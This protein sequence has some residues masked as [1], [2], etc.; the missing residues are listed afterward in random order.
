M[1][2]R[3]PILLLPAVL[4]FTACGELEEEEEPPQGVGEG[5]TQERLEQA[6][7]HPE[8]WVTYGG[9]YWEDR[10]S[11]L[12]E[13]DR[14]T[15]A[16]LGLE[17]AHDL[18]LRGGHETTPLVVD[19]VMIVTGPWSVVYAVDVRTGER[20]WTYDP[21]VPRL[22]GIY[23]CCDRV[24]RGAALYEGKVIVGTLDGRL[25]AVDATD[26]TQ[27]W[28]V[29]TVDPDRRY[30]ITGA[31]RVVQGLAI[32][33]NG[34]AELGVRG[35]VTAYDAE[36]GD[37]VWRTYTVPGDPSEPFESEAIARAAETWTGEWWTVGGGGTAWDAMA[38]DPELELL[39]IG[40]GNGS[41]WS[42]YQRSPGG[43]DNLYL[44][45]I[46]AL[47]PS[48]GELV[49]YYQT[50]PGDHWD[51]TATQPL[52]LADLE[53]DGRLRR[54]IMQAPKN[55]IFY[56]IDRETGEF[57][58]GEPYV[59]VTWMTG[60]DEK[61]RPIENPE[62]VWRDESVGV[63]P[64]FIGGH[65][66]QPM[67][68]NAETGLMYLPV[69][70]L[71]A[72]F[73]EDETW[74]YDPQGY[75]IGAV[76]KITD[77]AGPGFLLAWDPVEQ[78]AAWRVPLAYW[79]NGGVLTTAGGLV[80]QG[81]ADGRFVAYDAETG[82]LLWEA[83]TGM[84]IIAPPVTYE[85]DGTQYVS[86]VAGWGGVLHSAVGPVGEAAKYEQ[87][88]RV[89][90]F[91]LGGD[92]E[93]PSLTPRPT[94]PYVPTNDLPTDG[95]SIAMGGALFESVCSACHGAAGGSTGAYPNLQNATQD[96]HNSFQEIVLSGIREPLGMPSFEG[97]F[98]PEQVTLMQA[99]I[100]DAARTASEGR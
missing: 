13:I 1:C 94:Q 95:E 42:R 30:T 75:N 60:F 39:Y 64:S 21:G 99:Y 10:F 16:G 71:A 53:I 28:E 96:V 68:F 49:W 36:T 81:G 66:W 15:V 5:V 29:S 69:Q 19:G 51:Y 84:G 4:L 46:I 25:V 38:Y 87:R 34:G 59:P 35:Y 11:P 62:A 74:E 41:P 32:I 27:L 57:I 3:A 63:S 20:L 76:S 86:V 88:G 58:S 67:A 92:A 23:A 100:V 26:G 70:E 18:G 52:V 7:D 85:V 91:T 65:S 56:V 97:M 48:D 98:T 78:E 73:R 47:R 50:T 55:G 54:T 17:W 6:A 90:T 61:G 22:Y 89:F 8:E 83:S 93:W 82:D 72:D 43:G 12:D 45:S 31:P 80:F 14:E 24:N 37:Q 2:S 79:W 33:G 40:T 77:W 44:S 9:T